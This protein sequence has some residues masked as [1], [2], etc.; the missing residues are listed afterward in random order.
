M[1]YP[2]ELHRVGLQL[3]TAQDIWGIAF[4]PDDWRSTEREEPMPTL[5]TPPASEPA[6]TQPGAEPVSSLAGEELTIRLLQELQQAADAHAQEFQERLKELTQR[7]GMELEADLRERAARAKA[8]EVGVLEEEVRVLKENLSSA[9]KE[10]AKLEAKVMELKGDL[11]TT[12][13]NLAPPPLQEAR[14]QLAALTNNVVE[15]MNRAAEAGLSEYRGLL[16]R[17]NQETVLRV[18]KEPRSPGGSAPK[19]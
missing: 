13:G 18:R 9:R 15:S 7:I 10:I 8:H 6:E 17:E 11:E 2:G 19:P 14:K 12:I 5:E 3:V 1:R 4:P 16:R